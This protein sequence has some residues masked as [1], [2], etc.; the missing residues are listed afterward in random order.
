MEVL[1]VDGNAAHATWS[2]G[3]GLSFYSVV[4]E[5]KSLVYSGKWSRKSTVVR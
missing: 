2:H 5:Q 3:E 4:T 1:N